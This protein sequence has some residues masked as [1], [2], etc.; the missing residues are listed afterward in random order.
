MT[1]V[2]AG[3]MYVNAAIVIKG[4][5]LTILSIALSI[6]LIWQVSNRSKPEN[7]RMACLAGLAF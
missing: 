5:F 2:C 7:Y 3:G 4:F 1:L 6:Y